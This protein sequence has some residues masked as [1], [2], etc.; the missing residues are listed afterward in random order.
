MRKRKKILRIQSYKR[1]RSLLPSRS[2]QRLMM[3]TTRISP[4]IVM[5]RMM[6]LFQVWGRVQS[7][8]YSMRGAMDEYRFRLSYRDRRY[9]RLVRSESVTVLIQS[10]LNRA[11]RNM[12]SQPKMI[13][14]IID[15][16]YVHNVYC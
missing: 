15:E 1:K 7:G 2:L 13:L 5:T 6:M 14:I 8:K 4:R 12:K 9:C 11:R 16:R 10:R 3:M